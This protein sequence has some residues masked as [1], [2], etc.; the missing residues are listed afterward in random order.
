MKLL[1]TGATGLVGRRLVQKAFSLGIEIHFL[2]TSKSKTDSIAGA[3][4]FHWNPS[5]A[6]IESACFEGVDVLN[7]LIHTLQI[8]ILM[9]L[10]FNTES[11]AIGFY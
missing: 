4:G 6:E 9:I 7:L 10:K 5:K 8:L 2:T 3:K 1:I 11:S